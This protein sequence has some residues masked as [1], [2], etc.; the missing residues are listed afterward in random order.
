MI[1]G[2]CGKDVPMGQEICP[3]CGNPLKAA[4]PWDKPEKKK[5]AAKKTERP[6]K[7]EKPR[8]EPGVRYEPVQPTPIPEK[9]K[10]GLTVLFVIIGLSC[11]VFIKTIAINT[12]M[13]RSFAVGGVCFFLAALFSLIAKRKPKNRDG[14]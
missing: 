10:Y 8:Q 1:C 5:T 12:V 11:F 3:E 2:N 6:P 13:S 14:K 7:P 9:K 4:K